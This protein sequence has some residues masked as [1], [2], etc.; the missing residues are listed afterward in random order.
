MTALFDWKSVSDGTFA[1]IC[2]ERGLGLIYK[3]EIYI[4]KT[5]KNKIYE[6]APLVG[7]RV[8]ASYKRNPW[9]ATCY[10]DV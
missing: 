10:G 4:I 6:D 9:F 3:P 2:R 5:F 8:T 1:Q 7:K